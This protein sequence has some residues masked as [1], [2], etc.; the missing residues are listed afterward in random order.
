MRNALACSVFFFVAL[1][2]PVGILFAK[3]DFLSAFITCFLPIILI[4]Y[5]LVLAGINMSKE[6]IILPA[7]VWSG[8]IVLAALAALVRDSTGGQALTEK[9]PIKRGGAGGLSGL[10][11]SGSGSCCISF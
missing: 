2:A 8:N 4:Y 5:P 11:S 7:V 6:G 10:C 3:R 9:M 1:G